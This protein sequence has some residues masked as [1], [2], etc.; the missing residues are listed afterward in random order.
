[1]ALQA[2]TVCLVDAQNTRL[3]SGDSTPPPYTPITIAE[4]TALWQHRSRQVALMT[5][6]SKL[7]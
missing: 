1:L 2:I 7:G 4:V 5:A 3:I 6:P